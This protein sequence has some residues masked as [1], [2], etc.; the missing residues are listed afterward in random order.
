MIFNNSSLFMSTSELILININIMNI[1][2]HML[3]CLF[4]SMSMDKKNGEIVTR[5]RDNY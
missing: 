2:G 3:I 1:K 5:T 4:I